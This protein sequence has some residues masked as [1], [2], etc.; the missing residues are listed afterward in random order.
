[1]YK[2]K[3]QTLISICM[4]TVV[5]L[6]CSITA[7]ASATSTTY[8]VWNARE[9]AATCITDG[10]APVGYT[11]YVTADIT[12]H[13]TDQHIFSY[14]NCKNGGSTSATAGPVAVTYPSPI[15]L[16]SYNGGHESGLYPGS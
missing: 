4:L 14:T 15:P 16:I 12:S 10:N 8:V 9:T 3:I 2:Q 5:V 13:S 11:Y 6:S 1:M 7:L